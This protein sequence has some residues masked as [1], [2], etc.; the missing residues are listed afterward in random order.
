MK[1]DTLTNSV[2]FTLK[3]KEFFFFTIILIISHFERSFEDM[4]ENSPNLELTSEVQNSA[5]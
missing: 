2:I 3:L 4:F 5:I 1:P